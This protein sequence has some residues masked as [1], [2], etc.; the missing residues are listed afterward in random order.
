MTF[1]ELKKEV[2]SLTKALGVANGVVCK[3][4]DEIAK[5]NNICELNEKHYKEE[6][7]RLNTIVEYLESRK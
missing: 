1:K 5:L 3:Q 2:K 4:I 6:I 7:A